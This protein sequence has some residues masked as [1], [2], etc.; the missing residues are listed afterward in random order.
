MISLENVVEE[1][2]VV[3]E[4]ELSEGEEEIAEEDFEE[5]I[6]LTIEIVDLHK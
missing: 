6:L 2:D 1:V 4:E 3:A 5:I